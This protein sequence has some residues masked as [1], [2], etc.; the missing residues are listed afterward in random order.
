MCKVTC[1]MYLCANGPTT[2]P[3]RRAGITVHAL[4]ILGRDEGGASLYIVRSTA[5]GDEGQQ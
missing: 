2:H 5:V 1:E 4:V 3:P